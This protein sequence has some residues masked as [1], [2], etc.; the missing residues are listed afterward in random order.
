MIWRLLA[1]D[2]SGEPL[3]PVGTSSRPCRRQLAS[4]RGL[5]AAGWV[6]LCGSRGMRAARGCL[7]PHP[8]QSRTCGAHTGIRISDA[9]LR[10]SV[11]LD[12]RCAA[13]AWVLFHQAPWQLCI[14][15]A[16][17]CPRILLVLLATGLMI[18]A[19]SGNEDAEVGVVAEKPPTA[20]VDCS[21]DDFEPGSND[22]SS[23]SKSDGIS[24]V[25]V[26]STC[27]AS[28]PLSP[29]HPPLTCA[30]RLVV[31]GPIPCGNEEA[32]TASIGLI[33]WVSELMNVVSPP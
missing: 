26:E 16:T 7:S 23:S 22:G 4:D 18:F 10:L 12:S 14:G 32:S 13:C 20:K 17:F 33:I 9:L 27:K 5:L 29:P 19:H 30:S 21:D 24:A 31:P 11:R 3:G 6:L 1:V 2:P 15:S 25:V 8:G 28:R